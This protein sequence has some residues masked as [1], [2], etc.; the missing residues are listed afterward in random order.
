MRLPLLFR[1]HESSLST[2]LFVI[3]R[4]LSGIVST[5]RVQR[6]PRFH[7]AHPRGAETPRLPEGRALRE[8]RDKPLSLLTH[9]TL[10]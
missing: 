4:R 9:P 7:P 3:S 5:A 8:Q 6:G 1:F 10:H 2:S